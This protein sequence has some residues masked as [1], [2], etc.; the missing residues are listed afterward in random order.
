MSV[1]NEMAQT[2]EDPDPAA[3]GSDRRGLLP[4]RC[5][6]AGGNTRLTIC[7]VISI[8][9]ATPHRLAIMH[10]YLEINRHTLVIDARISLIGEKNCPEAEWPNCF[11]P[12]GWMPSIITTFAVKTRP[13]TA[14]AAGSGSSAFEPS[15]DRNN[16]N[17]TACRIN[18]R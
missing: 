16:K 10:P 8:A 6:D 2:L 13:I 9:M 14:R 17:T 1:S 15:H 11:R 5:N 12:D 18:E 4:Q 7:S 3:S